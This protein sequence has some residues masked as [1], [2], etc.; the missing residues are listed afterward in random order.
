MLLLATTVAWPWS[1]SPG[2][3]AAAQ[4]AGTSTTTLKNFGKVNDNYYR[5]SQ[6]RENEIEQ[7]K[8]L[9]VKTVIDL[10]KD[11]VPQAADWVSRAGMKYFNIP[12][13]P[14]RRATDE[15]TAYFLSLVNDPANGPVYVH[16]KGG[17]HRTG[18]LTAVYRITHDGWNADQAW[19]E[20]K[21]YDFNDG[22]FGGPADQK[23]FVYVF[24]QNYLANQAA[25]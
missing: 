23:K 7:L 9:G 15:Q 4:V 17:R 22:F 13:K 3:T 14:G 2:S 24:Y 16:C 5:G 1:I 11:K 19:D 8:R 18:A 12:M 10:R 20:M 25:K 6:P 21:R